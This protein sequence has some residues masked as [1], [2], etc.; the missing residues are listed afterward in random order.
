MRYSPTLLCLLVFALLTVSVSAAPAPSFSRDAFSK[1]A[2]KINRAKKDVVFFFN[3]AKETASIK[4]D[5][6]RDWNKD[7]ITTFKK[8]VIKWQ[9]DQLSL[10]TNDEE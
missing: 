2:G 3:E 5:D 10:D 4:L 7:M 9:E 1:V 6:F 8:E